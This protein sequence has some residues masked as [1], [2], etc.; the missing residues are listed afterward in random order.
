MDERCTVFLCRGCCCGH[1]RKHP[2][3]EHAAHLH[4][5]REQAGNQTAVRV[6]DC[7]GPCERSNVVVLVP[8][9]AARRAGARPVWLGWVLDTTAIDAIADWACAGG[10]GIAP[11]PPLLELHQFRPPP[12]RTGTR[13]MTYPKPASSAQP[14]HPRPAV[15]TPPRTRRSC[16]TRST[17]TPNTPS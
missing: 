7:L 1:Q 2:H 11:P 13:P 6:S 4:R 3:V 17:S 10:P 9:R 5:L 8:S 14:A 12:H 15:P 16:A